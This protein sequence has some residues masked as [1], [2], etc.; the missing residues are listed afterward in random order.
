MLAG[1]KGDGT[2][3]GVVGK[4]W[5]G[6]IGDWTRLRVWKRDGVERPRLFCVRR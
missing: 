2:E 4:A 5:L 3:A 6:D 1:T